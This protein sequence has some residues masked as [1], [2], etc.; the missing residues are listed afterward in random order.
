MSIRSSLRSTSHPLIAGLAVV[1]LLPAL[2][3]GVA[4]SDR[5]PD[6]AAIQPTRTDRQPGDREAGRRPAEPDD[7]AGEAGA[8]PAALRRP[9]HRRRRQGGR[10]RRVQPDRPGED[11]PP[12]AR[13]GGAVPAAHP[14]PLRLRHDP[15][16][17]HRVPHPAGDG[18][19]VRPAGRLR[20]RAVRRPGDRG[21]RHQAGLQPHGRRLARAPLGPDRRGQR[22]GP[23]PRVG[24]GGRPG[25]GRPG[26]GTTARPT[27]WS[28]ASSTSPPTGSPRAAATTTRPTCPSS[29]LRNL[30]LPP[31]KAAVDA[32]A[33]TAMCS[34]NAINGVPGCAN[35]ETETQILKQEW[36]FD[37]FI[38]S[39]YTAVD[40]LRACPP[41]TPGHGPV[42]A[43]RRGRR[44]LR[45]RPGAERRDR[46]G[47]GQH[48]HPRLRRPAAGQGQ[49]SRSRG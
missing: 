39:D 36:G 20:R 30:Y 1:A 25:Q 22:R 29:G 2:A 23:V 11:Q 45:R 3:G 14:D 7:P 46:H 37:G 9:G 33:D 18:Q 10:R 32:G 13:G 31:F 41:K 34:F 35:P 4:A 28:P 5:P 8:D 47:D 49:R 27:R 6:E 42:R 19:L 43:R 16:L 21:R 26:R 12:A 24:D 17:P 48:Q 44:P 38:E 40:E 15:R